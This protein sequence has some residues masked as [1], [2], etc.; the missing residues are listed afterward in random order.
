MLIH[1][2]NINSRE[3]VFEVSN[4]LSKTKATGASTFAEEHPGHAQDAAP[5]AFPLT[6]I[7]FSY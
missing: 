7:V 5:P 2:E 6:E 1:I 4:P 3:L